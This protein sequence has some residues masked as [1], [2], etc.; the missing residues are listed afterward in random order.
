MRSTL[1][2]AGLTPLYHSLDEAA[3]WNLNVQQT[4]GIR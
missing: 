3:E 4:F 2:D 1:I